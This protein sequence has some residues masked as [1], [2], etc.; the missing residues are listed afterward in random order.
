MKTTKKILSTV[1][2]LL[3][4]IIFIGSAASAQVIKI[5]ETN[6]PDT[7]VRNALNDLSNELYKNN[8]MN[9]KQDSIKVKPGYINTE[10]VDILEIEYGT[11][12][13]LTGLESFDNL[14]YLNIYNFSGSSISLSNSF[15]NTDSVFGIDIRIGNSTADVVDINLPN[16][17]GEIS[18]ENQKTRTL[19]INAPKLFSLRIS[20]NDKLNTIHLK[21]IA[22]L[23]YFMMEQVNC[24]S[25]HLPDCSNL[26]SLSIDDTKISSI[27]KKGKENIR[28]YS[29]L[30]GSYICFH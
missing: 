2:L 15:K 6:F 10:D 12:T 19:N 1:I 4:G 17:V 20:G 28:F 9:N 29:I 26:K 25:V 13:S 27:P 21:S 14:S 8:S 30:N 24:T 5:D 18:L 22:S 11:V 3:T 23:E 7:A 16:A